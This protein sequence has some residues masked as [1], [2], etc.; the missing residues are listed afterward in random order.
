M[1]VSQF[2][3]LDAFTAKDSIDWSKTTM[4]HLDEY[5]GLSD[6]HRASFQKYLDERFISKVNPGAVHLIRG[7]VPDS[8]REC[9]RL[10]DI[11]GDRRIDVSSIGIGENDHIAFNDPPAD[12][13]DERTVH[14]GRTGPGLSGTAGQRRLVRESL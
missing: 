11:I 7:G 5:I 3:F 10:D 2:D 9:N 6:D 12:F 14:R 4:F 8:Q 13:R 1:G